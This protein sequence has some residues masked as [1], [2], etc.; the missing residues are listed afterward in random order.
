M[1]CMGRNTRDGEAGGGHLFG[2]QASY[3]YLRE[4]LWYIHIIQ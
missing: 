1:P 2:L 3:C 4:Y